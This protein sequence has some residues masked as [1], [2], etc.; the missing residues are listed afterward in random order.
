[1]R[2][3]SILSLSKM[4]TLQMSWGENTEGEADGQRMDGIESYGGTAMCQKQWFLAKPWLLFVFSSAYMS[5]QIFCSLF[6]SMQLAGNLSQLVKKGC[7]MCRQPEEKMASDASHWATGRVWVLE[8]CWHSGLVDSLF[9]VCTGGVC[10]WNCWAP[11]AAVSVTASW[12][13]AELELSRELLKVDCS[14]SPLIRGLAKSKSLQ[15][16][17]W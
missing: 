14:D 5:V 9:V 8:L 1:M 16:W 7:Q 11:W 15:F 3:C 2:L 13:R 4:S 6:R 12:N 10:L 17:D